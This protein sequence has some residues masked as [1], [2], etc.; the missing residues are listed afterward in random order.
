VSKNFEDA[1]LFSSAKELE[2]ASKNKS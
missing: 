1:P 2:K